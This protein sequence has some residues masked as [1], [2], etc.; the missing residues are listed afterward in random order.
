MKFLICSSSTL[1]V[2]YIAGTLSNSLEVRGCFLIQAWM[3]QLVAHWLDI[4]EVMDSN[5][6]KGDDLKKS[7]FEKSINK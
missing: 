2:V 7:E 4:M 1:I 5:P 6:G 3:A